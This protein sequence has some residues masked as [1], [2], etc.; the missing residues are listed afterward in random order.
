MILKSIEN[1]NLVHL[2]NCDQEPIHIPGSI[3]PHGFLLVLNKDYIIIFCSA[4]L[5]DYGLTTDGALSKP[6]SS[7]LTGH[8]AAALTLFLDKGDF[9][10]SKP[11][12][13]KILD[14]L[15]NVTVH[16]TGDRLALE[17]E[18]FPDGSLEL[19]NLYQQTSKFTAILSKTLGL[20]QLC[21]S[22]SEEVK[23]ITGYDRVMIY[24]FDE[25]YNGEVFAEAVND[26][27]EPF[28]G[29]HYPHTDIPVQA[30]ELYL[31]NLMRMI[32]DV[33]YTPVPILTRDQEAT[34]QQVDLSNSILR[35]VSPIHIE[36][37]KNMGVS[38]TLTI[39][40]IL[41]GKLW[42]LIACHH[43]SAK[44][45][46]HYIRISALLQGHFLTSQIRVQEVKADYELKLA[47]DNKLKF[48]LALLDQ[49]SAAGEDNIVSEELAGLTNANGISIV[50]GSEIYY[51]GDVPEHEEI[52]QLVKKIHDTNTEFS[53]S[54]NVGRDY[55][56]NLSNQVAGFLYYRIDA[57]TSIIWFRNELNKE[58]RW[59]GEPAKS[60]V[61]NK[62]GLSPRKSFALWKEQVTGYS[63]EWLPAE[64]STANQAA[65]SI[66]KHFS[67]LKD[68]KIQSTQNSLLKQ[69]KQ[70]NEEL[71]NINWISTHDLKEPLR[72]IRVFA[73]I[74]LD[75]DKH[76]LNEHSTQLLI[77]MSASVD[78]MQTLLDD[79]ME[80][81][82]VKDGIYAY[83][84]TDMNSLIKNV[85]NN[86]AELV[87]GR[88]MSFHISQLPVI[89]CLPVLI[90]QLFTNLISN[91]IKFAKPEG[92]LTIKIGGSPGWNAAG[93]PHFEFTFQDNGTGFDNAYNEQIFQVFQRLERSAIEGSGIGLAICRKIAAIH[94][95]YITAQGEK[96]EGATFKIALPYDPL[97]VENQVI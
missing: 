38:G 22:I 35:S 90:E 23:T 4:N 32:V 1:T 18:P 50:N 48:F 43:Y 14:E 95:G 58:V 66:Q 74:L 25:S 13:C 41:E 28:L 55:S 83:E 26:D 79:L 19:S 10:N 3:Q 2:E 69:L 20:Q 51:W 59:A 15:F 68:K 77:R 12:A 86:N 71:E 17:F 27:L 81:S 47:L 61:K 70:A 96:N 31:R 37:L 9:E 40:L 88:N 5:T 44:N 97:A 49:Y 46:P 78:K 82:K 34:N 65:Y 7:I 93:A 85:I 87:S 53:F 73:S 36:Y 56:F 6:L 75:K 45:I 30:R 60:I 42:G 72:K 76:Q 8:E 54:N 24:R 91:S 63:S 39:S 89:N 57:A 21:Q 52:L 11:H 80:L 33:N 92:K 64:V 84:P 62:S 94:R 16:Y 29:L 67:S